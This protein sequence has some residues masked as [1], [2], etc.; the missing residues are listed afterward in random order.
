MT[1]VPPENVGTN[2]T[3]ALYGGVA[4]LGTMLLASG[5]VVCTVRVAGPLAIAPAE[6]ET[7]TVN[8]EPLSPIAAA[9]VV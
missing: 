7:V 5:V 9:G 1:A 6:F 4:V 3:D 2:C 8:T